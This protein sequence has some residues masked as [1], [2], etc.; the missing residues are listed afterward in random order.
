MSIWA[1]FIPQMLFLHSIFGYLVVCIFIKWA[2]NWE[3]S[4]TAPPNLLNMLIAM[5]L[6]P[7][8][9][10]PKE[11]L[12][13]GQGPL[14]IFLLLLA[15]VCVPWMLCVKPYIQYK[16]LKKTKAQGYEA[17]HNGHD[18]DGNGHG[19]RSLDADE[20]EQANP[21]A[22]TEYTEDEH[23]EVGRVLYLATD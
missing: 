3:T 18:D 17:V 4:S 6:S 15:L 13:R 2:T 22:V 16:E 20:E 14:Q 10:D 21:A 23:D 7:G 12:F 9:I 19:R 8:S 1:E 11:Q 5:F